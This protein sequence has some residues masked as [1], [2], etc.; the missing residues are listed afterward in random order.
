[1]MLGILPGGGEPPPAVP[2]CYKMPQ[3]SSYSE[4]QPFQVSQ[5]HFLSL[6]LLSQPKCGHP[7]CLSRSIM[8]RGRRTHGQMVQIQKIF[9]LTQGLCL[10]MGLL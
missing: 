7:P 2:M 5:T 9:T 10:G 1:M 4:L 8:S 6:H 3:T